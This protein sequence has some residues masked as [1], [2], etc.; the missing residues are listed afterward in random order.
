M[1]TL[2]YFF[3]FLLSFSVVS[4]FGDSFEDISSLEKIWSEVY[5]YSDSYSN[6]TYEIINGQGQ[7]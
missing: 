3:I 2:T 5:S 1:K 4:A 6:G 7:D